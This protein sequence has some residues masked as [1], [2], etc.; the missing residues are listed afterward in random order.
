MKTLL[1]DRSKVG[2]IANP[3]LCQAALIV[4]L[5]WVAAAAGGS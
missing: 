3:V 2:S 5:A 1:F 4:V